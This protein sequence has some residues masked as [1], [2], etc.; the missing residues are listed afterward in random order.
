ML[1][2]IGEWLLRAAA[3]LVVLYL[4]ALVVYSLHRNRKVGQVLR[5]Q[6]G[7]T[8]FNGKSLVDLRLDAPKTPGPFARCNQ[9]SETPSVQPQGLRRNRRGIILRQP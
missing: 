8:D 7:R 2:L 5:M 9:T 3:F 4:L 1:G 6:K